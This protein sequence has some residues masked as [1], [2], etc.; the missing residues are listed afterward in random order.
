[1]SVSKSETGCKTKTTVNKQEKLKLELNTKQ[2]KLL[3]G[4]SVMII[5]YSTFEID[6]EKGVM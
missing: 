6:I 5:Y 2:F 4:F 1:M 3:N